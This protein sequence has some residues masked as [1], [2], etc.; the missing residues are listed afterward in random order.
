LKLTLHAEIAEIAEIRRAP[1][2]FLFSH[3][4]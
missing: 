4:A 1:Q 3:L 2:S